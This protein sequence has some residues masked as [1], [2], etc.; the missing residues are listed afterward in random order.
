MNKQ[1]LELQETSLNNWRAKY[2][3]NY[4]TY[5]IKIE[6]AGKKVLNYSCSCP[7][8]YYPCK[9]IA[10]VQEAIKERME[11]KSGNKENRMIEDIVRNI[12]EK[13]LKSFIIRTAVYNPTLTQALLLEFAPR[14]KPSGKATSYAEIIRSALAK[15]CVEIDDIYYGEEVLEIDPLNDWL[16][17]AKK[18]VADNNYSEAVSIA[19]A[20][21]E[22]AAQWLA[23]KF[24]E[25]D[26]DDYVS[27]DYA[28]I[29]FDILTKAKDAGYFTANE[30]LRY[31]QEE[32][33]K[34][35][36]RNAGIFASL[37][38]FIMKLT[39]ETDPDTYLK[40]QEKLF[41]QLSDKTSYEAKRILTK[42]IN[43]YQNRNEEEKAWGI[44]SSNIQI[45]SFRK[46]VVEKL[47]AEQQ[48]KEAM[49]LIDDYL[50]SQES[51]KSYFRRNTSDWDKL[52]LDIAQKRND[53]NGIRTNSKR[54]IEE[55]FSPTYYTIYKSTF[56][57]EKWEAEMNK[58]IKQYCK[59]SHFSYNAADLLVNEK[60]ISRLLTY[61]EQ[62]YSAD[63][64]KKYYSHTAQNF[65]D[66]TIALF[67]RTID[68][69]LEST[70]REVYEHTIRLFEDMLNI[71]GGEKEV[72]NMIDQY[73]V[74]YKNRKAM[75]EIFNRFSNKYLK[76]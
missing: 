51:E 22:E 60:L 20:C 32:I 24:E 57:A 68:K 25:Y 14:Q 72:R 34:E 64:L 39:E 40:I 48:F 44:V 71:K 50:K 61:M 37:N 16:R 74:L 47:I 59:N 28:E 30:L 26:L 65:P 33:K 27:E 17:K 75:V 54:L 29:P 23:D 73:K 67:K 10:I 35:K 7:S 76:K 56:Q 21:L 69:Q 1:I 42:I 70:G 63:T 11:T 45:E 18:Y 19:K 6:T 9:H 15:V 8:S 66:R 12:P 58:L 41:E 49:R 31:L 3:G 36:Y 46:E 38:N 55:R 13:E 4:G 53:I 5:T 52:L 62:G 2:K 43:F